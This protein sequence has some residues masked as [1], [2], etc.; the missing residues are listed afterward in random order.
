MCRCRKSAGVYVVEPDE[1][2]ASYIELKCAREKVRRFKLL[3]AGLDHIPLPD[4]STDSQSSAQSRK[5]SQHQ[6]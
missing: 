3:R 4:D 1:A 6:R 2:I 5:D